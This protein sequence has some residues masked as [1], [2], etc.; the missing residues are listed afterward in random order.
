MSKARSGFLPLAPIVAAMAH[1]P[2]PT[3]P[4]DK[5]D[6]EEKFEPKGTPGAG[7]KFLA[8]FAGEWTLEKSFFSAPSARRTGS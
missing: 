5:K 1:G 4:G 7:R 3:L 8:R 6:S 2:P